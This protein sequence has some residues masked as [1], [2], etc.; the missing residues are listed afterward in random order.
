MQT[1]LVDMAADAATVSALPQRKAAGSGFRLIELYELL[2]L[3]W[4]CIQLLE[5]FLVIAI[6]HFS[7]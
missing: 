3:D 4:F 1:I 2:F 6:R 7:Y 5:D